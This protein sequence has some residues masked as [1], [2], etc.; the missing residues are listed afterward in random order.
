MGVSRYKVEYKSS[1]ED[2]QRARGW[3]KDNIA[4][5][6]EYDKEYYAKNRTERIK[7]NADTQKIR[8]RRYRIDAMKKIAAYH[9]TTVQC[10]RCGE[11]RM[12]VLAIVFTDATGKE[13]RENNGYGSTKY[14][15]RIIDGEKSCDNLQIQCYNCSMCMRFHKKYPDEISYE[16][17]VV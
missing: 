17:Y 1:E 3:R 11:T 15:R 6:R 4:A 12:W 16:S 14:Y 10:N 7:T 5:K 9:N 2:L 13:D 8:N